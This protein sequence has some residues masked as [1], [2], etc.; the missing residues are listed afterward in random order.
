MAREKISRAVASGGGTAI[1]G[2]GPYRPGGIGW[3]SVTITAPGQTA[4]RKFIAEGIANGI[5]R[6]LLAWIVTSGTTARISFDSSLDVGAAVVS[7]ISPGAGGNASGHH[8]TIF[9]RHNQFMFMTALTILGG[10][11]FT[12][13]VFAVTFLAEVFVSRCL[14][15]F[16]ENK[17]HPMLQWREPIFGMGILVVARDAS[18]CLFLDPFPQ[19]CVTQ[20]AGALQ[21]RLT[22]EIGLGVISTGRGSPIGIDEVRVM[23]MAGKTGWGNVSALQ[24]DSVTVGTEIE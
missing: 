9:V 19:F 12:P 13:E 10:S 21:T 24:V 15:N 6:T 20:S 2:A 1:G 23:G 11:A 5:G 14:S 8:T 7:R 16:V 18:R 17:V 3:Q 4:G 22:R